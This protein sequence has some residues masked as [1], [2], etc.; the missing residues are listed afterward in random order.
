LLTIIQLDFLPK[1]DK[2]MKNWILA[3]C[4]LLAGM[5]SAYA[6]DLALSWAGGIGGANN[7]NVSA[8]I[9]DG[10][11]N[12]Y[13]AGQF[14]VIADF[15]FSS[16]TA[17][18]VANNRSMFL[19]KYDADGNHVW[20]KAIGGT[21]TGASQVWGR[22]LA[23][24]S[25]G[26]LVVTGWCNGTTDFDP[27]AGVETLTGAYEIFIAKYSADGDFVWAK[28]VSGGGSGDYGL[29]IAVNQ[30]DEIFV[31][32]HFQATTDFDPGI[33]TATLT[34][35]GS[36][37]AFLAKY[38][39]DGNYIWAFALGGAATNTL[40]TADRGNS[41]AIDSNGDVLLTGA[42]SGT[43]DFD[44]GTASYTLTAAG[45]TDIFLAKYSTAGT[46]IW[47]KAMGS[48]GPTTS[49]DAGNSVVVDENGDIY[50]T[51]FFANQVDFNPGGTTLELTANGYKSD[52]FVARYAAD[53]TCITAQALGGM[54]TDVGSSISYSTGYLYVTGSFTD[55]FEVDL[56]TQTVTL[57]SK[58]ESDIFIL[59]LDTAGTYYWAG[60]AGGTKVDAGVVITNDPWGNVLVSG[61]FQDTADLNPVAQDTLLINSI[62]SNDV[63][64][65]K[66][67]LDCDP[68]GSE[69]TQT[70]CDSFN[71]F[72]NVLYTGGTYTD[73]LSTPFGCDSIITLDLTIHTSPSADFS[74]ISDSLVATDGASWQ[75][76]D[77]T[78]QS[79]VPGANERV[80]RPQQNGT[81]AVIVGNENGCS[82]TSSCQLF[83]LEDVG[84][85]ALQRNSGFSLYPNP[86][87]DRV[88]ISA[89]QGLAKAQVRVLN[90]LGQVLTQI[91]GQTGNTIEM[92]IRSLSTGVYLVE[93][94]Q[95]KSKMLQ[96]LTI[97]K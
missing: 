5:G 68:V 9:T 52:I 29:G 54:N 16:A 71:F 89:K 19:A 25:D 23:L 46:L 67:H 60:Q 18:L 83:E 79:A 43:A 21:A 38:D 13:I 97:Q 35:S 76:V 70:A 2:Y 32:G 36:H 50:L 1:T 37:D 3:L 39:A 6:Q 34:A 8:L 69:L 27:G 66:L 40:A 61:Q 31:T 11:G 24:D 7:D 15:D 26:N 59:K 48:S 28:S 77:C 72:G 82:D 75:W 73:T 57:A 49:D 12:S 88:Y 53:G 45:G 41:V 22:A 62:G 80:F 86:A 56:G 64:L 42:F 84:I 30:D 10:D 92:D 95:Q 93:V 74:I 85:S 94:V 14:L 33:G 47:A 51:G 65:I 78:T 87:R 55:S 81:F 17:N 90:T 63:F 91:N 20:S 44:P 96:K 58:G 4:T